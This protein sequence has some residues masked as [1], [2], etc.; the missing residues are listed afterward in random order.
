[1]AKNDL[2]AVTNEEKVDIRSYDF[3]GLESLLHKKD[4]TLRIVNFWATWCKPC[5][6][7]LPAF[8]RVAQ[9]FSGK[10]VKV[11]FVSLDFPGQKERKLI[12]F[13]EERNMK[14]VILL[15]DPKSNTWIPK[16]D[17]SWSGAIPATLIYKKEQRDFYESGFDYSSL[18]EAIA[19][20][21]FL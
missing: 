21:D 14:N 13:V 17:E 20:Y 15:D 9:E 16:V 8:E 10:K 1:M 12:P 2:S 11:I 5:V 3:D 4:D 18:K 6:N 7:E 19:D